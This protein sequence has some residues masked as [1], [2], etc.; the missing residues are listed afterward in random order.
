MN[1]ILNYKNFVKSI[2]IKKNDK[3][4]INSNFL[5]IMIL[6]KKKKKNFDLIK[7]IDAFLNFLGNN[8][9]LFIP[10]YS[11]DFIKKKSFTYE[12][13]KSISGSISNIL[14]NNKRFL[15]TSNPIFSFFVAGKDKKKICSMQH[16]DSF[17]LKSPFGY[18]I[19][20]KGK[21]LFFDID[22]KDSF[23]FVHLAEQKVKVNYRFKKKFS[24]YIF[25]NSKKIKNT[26]SMYSRKLEM[27]VKGTKIDE[28][29]DK[30]LI[31]NNSLTK[32]K[33]S[34][35]NCQIININKAFKIMIDDL[36]SERKLIYP[37]FNK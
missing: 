34:G 26:T 2:G 33:I 20:N 35:I 22:Y 16:K 8:G 1:E 4:M 13:T 21:N 32:K 30:I 28:K 23:T 11:W 36:K 27:G 9:T 12:K 7:L 25:K 29:L 37:I 31:K 19:K 17:S 18:L 6:A 14:I 3:I 10:A 15:R 24:G 5:K